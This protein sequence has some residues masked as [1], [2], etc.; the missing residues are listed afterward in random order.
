MS[1]ATIAA[2]PVS[3]EQKKN[4]FFTQGDWLYWTCKFQEARQHFQTAQ[5]QLFL[6]AS[7][8]IRCYKSIGAAEVQLKNYDDAISTYQKQLNKLN[9]CHSLDKLQQIITC[10]ISIGKVYWLKQQYDQA[11]AY[12]QQA[13]ELTESDM[14]STINLSVIHKNLGNIYTN[15]KQFDLAYEHFQKALQIDGLHLPKDHPKI[16][17]T[18]ANMAV[19]YQSKQ[20]YQNALIYF[21]K[22]CEIFLNTFSKTH[23]SVEKL[24]KTIRAIEF[25]PS[26]QVNTYHIFPDYD[27]QF[28][29]KQP[30]NASDILTLNNTT[31]IWLDEHIG[32]DENCRD[33]KNEFRQITNSFKMV[34]SV[35]SCRQCL[36]YI[37]NRKVFFIIQGKHVQEI[38]PHIVQ[39]MSP[40]MKPVVYV[41]CL[42][43]AYLNEWAQEQEYIME[44]GMFDHEKDLLARL[45]SDVKKYIQQ[46]SEEK[47][48]FFEQ[49]NQIF[50]HCWRVK[51][52][53][54]SRH[55]TNIDENAP[56]AVVTH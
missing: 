50:E 39:I 20:D 44:G 28:I 17:Q 49:F 7:D 48:T 43:I 40:E 34:D 5:Q 12:H 15:A 19:M 13:L 38:I 3:D 25:S 42:H 6:N 18:Y 36:P 30:A 47:T 24:R 33:L 55:S 46:Q 16:A 41:F 56:V 14:D 9:E 1:S 8:L 22:A 29:S 27:L 54:A 37:K 4:D 11:I 2:V 32:L 21:E 31:I 26:L 23:V 10:Y 53:I 35:E 45:T 52:E 51:E